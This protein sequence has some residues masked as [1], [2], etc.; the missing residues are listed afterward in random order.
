M[1]LSELLGR[2][3]GDHGDILVRGMTLDS[4]AVVAGDAFLAVRGNSA[5]GL[6]FAPAALARG[7]SVIL[8][9]PPAPAAPYAAEPV[10]WI[11]N[12]RE[13]SQRKTE[14]ADRGRFYCSGL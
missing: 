6:S 1:R 14:Y 4:R 3:A 5:H 12:L 8:A 2:D 10:V 13:R 11:D 7:A 9:E